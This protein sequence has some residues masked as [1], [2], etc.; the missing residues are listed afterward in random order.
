M[1]FSHI[2]KPVLIG[3]AASGA[4]AAI[5]AYA[6]YEQNRPPLLEIYVFSLKNGHSLFIRTPDDQRILF[7]GG[8]NSEVIRSLTNILPFYDRHIDTIIVPSDDPKLVGGLIDVI[9]RYSVDTVYVP[10]FNS[11][12]TGIAST[13]SETYKTFLEHARARK[14]PLIS[15]RAGDEL[16]LGGGDLTGTRYEGGPYTDPTR[17]RILFPVPPAAFEYTKASPPAV[18]FH[19]RYNTTQVAYFGI[20]SKKVQKFTTGYSESNLDGSVT[21]P[22]LTA[23]VLIV[24]MNAHANTLSPELLK[25]VRP[26]TVIYSSMV[27]KDSTS[28]AGSKKK[29]KTL[30]VQELHTNAAIHTSQKKNSNKKS[31]DPLAAVL[32]DHRFNIKDQGTIKITSDGEVI[33]IEPWD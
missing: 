30:H 10:A 14:L 21:L 2:S 28:R 18:H 9:D 4:L 5:S 26:E 8:A 23:D 6:L 12:N 13:T 32:M 19:L 16:V 22:D 11:E 25:A 7:G 1:S 17:L 31:T 33:D 27:T 20:A 15:I 29:T 3:L 24:S